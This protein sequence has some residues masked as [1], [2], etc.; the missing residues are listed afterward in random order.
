MT[1]QFDELLGYPLPFTVIKNACCEEKIK[2]TFFSS[3]RKGQK[4]HE[5]EAAGVNTVH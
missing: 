4:S 3:Y 1:T 5:V 2:L